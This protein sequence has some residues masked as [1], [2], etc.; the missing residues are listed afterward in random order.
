MRNS[1]LPILYDLVVTIGEQTSLEPLLTR[2]LQRLL[3]HT[4][5]P[6]GL[7][8]LD[9]PDAA[10]GQEEI[11]A[12]LDAA[13]G[14]FDLIN[15]VGQ[16]L[17]LPR[18][19]LQGV[20][21]DETTQLAALQ[22]LRPVAG[23]YR[24]F[25]RLPLSPHGAIFLLAP[26]APET[27][28]PLTQ[29]F[30]PVLAHLSRA[31][32]LCRRSDAY[33]ASLKEERQLYATVFE[34][35]SSGV[36][37]THH[38]RH[39]MAVNQAFTRITGYSADEVLG[40]DPHLLSSGQHDP[41]FYDELWR[42]VN[43]H[44]Y[45]Q[46]E[47]WDRRKNGESYPEW[48]SISAVRDAQGQITHY[49]G[50]FSDISEEKKTESLLHQMAFYDSLTQLPNRRLL[51]DRLL[52]AC[53]SSA[54]TGQFGALL[55]MDLDDFKDI[56]DA[57]GHD[58]GDLLLQEVARRLLDCVREGDTVARLGGDEFVVILNAL[59]AL[60]TEAATHA[61]Q[62]A[63]KI[64]EALGQP[65]WLNSIAVYTSPSI[66]ITLFR[67]QKQDVDTLLKHAD[68]SMY[69]AKVAGGNSIQ[70]FDPR[71]QQEIDVRAEL[72]DALREAV[73]LEQ[74]SLHFQPQ[75]DHQQR[76]FG[77]EVL[78]RWKHPKLGEISPAQFIPLAEDSSLITLIGLWSLWGACV[79]LHTWQQQAATR[80][81]TLSLNVSPRQFRQPDF[82]QQVQDALR[83][84]GANAQ[85]LKLELTEGVMIDNPQDTALKMRTLQQMGVGFS[86]DDFG[87]GY[88]SLQYIKQLPIDQIKIDQSFTRDITSDPNDA[89]IVKTI[90]AMARSLDLQVIAEGV[91][92]QAQRDYLE[93]NG[94]LHYQGYLYGRPMPVDQLE[95][96]LSAKA[97]QPPV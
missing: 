97:G 24:S 59:G 50:I 91:E 47:I 5:Y 69:R 71:M 40:R 15:A 46:G 64:R 90:I 9:I 31:I 2:A 20:D 60:A 37:I 8:C 42:T 18:A 61:E 93:R 1:I 53:S 76:I 81:L 83:G 13:V 25:L 51:M 70:F 58:V 75:V 11:H 56:N 3:Y 36:V 82:V 33:T 30:K 35:S 34:S 68:I 87:T 95:T 21:V 39:I 79:Q 73:R 29:M 88:S 55:F 4:S 74:L 32:T 44:G 63:E 78:L 17:R 22:N 16:V 43:A 94:C 57:K 19:L 41:A 38:D 52:Q 85:R 62:V 6:V 92:T 86:L 28:L 49:V 14:D 7:I 45:W 10:D 80:D 12:R 66:G 26:V 77:A 96:I 54:R 27:R 67:D 48:L 72:V 65:C 84:S 23:R 89:L